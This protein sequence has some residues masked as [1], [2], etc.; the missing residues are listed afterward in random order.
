M[1]EC[2]IFGDA[3]LF[4]EF[5][6][7]RT[8]N[9][10]PAYDQPQESNPLERNESISDPSKPPPEFFIGCSDDSEPENS[11][12]GGTCLEEKPTGS[13]NEKE[14]DALK[15]EIISLKQKISVLESQKLRMMK[16]AR[17]TEV[18]ANLVLTEECPAFTVNFLNNRLARKYKAKIENFIS[19]LISEDDDAEKMPSLNIRSHY[20][21]L[22]DDSSLEKID[23]DKV[24][25]LKESYT[26]ISSCQYYQ[27]FIADSLGWPLVGGNPSLTD[28]W[29]IPSYEQIY[30]KSLPYNKEEDEEETRPQ[31]RRDK[32]PSCFNCGGCHTMR[33]CTEKKDPARIQQNRQE[34]MD[35]FSPATISGRSGRDPRYHGTDPRFNKFKPGV[36][37]DDLRKALCLREDELPP[38]IYQMR[39]YGYP[40]GHLQA[41]EISHSS[42]TMF[43]KH[44]R[45]TNK[46][47]EALEDGEVDSDRYGD[48]AFDLNA[49]IEYPGFNTTVPD[50]FVD[51][52]SRLSMPPLMPHQ[53]KHML[54]EMMGESMFKTIDKPSRKRKASVLL[55]RDEQ[56]MDLEDDSGDPQDTEAKKPVHTQISRII[57]SSSASSSPGST[58]KRAQSFSLDELEQQ[59]LQLLSQLANEEVSAAETD[60]SID[61]DGVV[62]APSGAS[63]PTRMKS[64]DQHLFSPFETPTAMTLSRSESIG[65]ELGT[66]VIEE[67]NQT[68][69]LPSPEKWSKDITE[70]IPYENL[71]EATGMY[72]KMRGVIR[73]VRKQTKPDKS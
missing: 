17:L 42:F 54:R 72:Q 18:P 2:D 62:S 9:G 16:I 35:K 70:H 1:A 48:L 14:K 23:K 58:P 27:M 33:E 51:D 36:I 31:K 60:P 53:Q 59:K 55:D 26:A 32:G 71:P 4:G 50:G 8:A 25:E 73:N 47:G 15:S 7:E 28:S 29:E 46:E 22:A 3:S 37:S 11:A 20:L 52:S 30:L 24:D 57:D 39:V 68:I 5:E 69:K 56:D 12:A 43:D 49:I 6:R 41:A 45:E 67:C 21:C 44:G 40:P 19:H 65:L 13:E 10:S 64:Q 66:P 38:Y 61:E 34:F 63:T